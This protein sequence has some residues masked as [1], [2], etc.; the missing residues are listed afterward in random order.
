[1]S[2]LWYFPLEVVTAR[3]TKQL[4]TQWMPAA[5]EALGIKW[6]TV[7]GQQSTEDIRVGAVLDAVQRCQFAMSQVD[8]FLHQV[9]RG[10]VRDGDVVF[11]Q[12]FWTP[13]VESLPYVLHQYGINV[14]M[15]A[16]VWAQSV[17]EFDFTYAMRHWM[18]AYELG[19]DK[20]LAGIF[21]AS[22]VHKQQLKD[23]GFEAPVHVVGLTID[24]ATFPRLASLKPLDQRQPVVVF[25]S[26]FDNEKNPRFMM[27][28]AERFLAAHPQWQWICTTSASSIRSNDAAVPTMLHQLSQ[29]CPRFQC[30]VVSKEGYYDILRDARVQ[31][32]CASQD[33][34][35]WTLLEATLAGTDIAYPDVR[36]FPECVP[37]DRRYRHLDIDDALRLLNDLTISNNL[38]Q[39]SDIAATCNQGRLIQAAIMQSASKP[40]EAN[41]WQQ[42]GASR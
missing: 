40:M 8:E 2:V 14:R 24:P 33:Y 6:R 42:F 18:R 12:D 32:N 15:Y 17:D 19:L 25:S 27:Q 5:F 22:S 30:K 39:H 9:Q 36:S 37:D 23:A 31:F 16:T 3:Y 35:S 20:V 1:M 29:R 21:V 28:V 13:G 38:R 10:N 7:E 11:L 26:R 4:C 34:V 41:V